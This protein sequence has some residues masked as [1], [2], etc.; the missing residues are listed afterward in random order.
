M[1]RLSISSFWRDWRAWISRMCLE[2]KVFK[3]WK[4]IKL[5]K[6]GFIQR[7]PK[8]SRTTDHSLFSEPTDFTLEIL[9]L[10]F[11]IVVAADVGVVEGVV[12]QTGQRGFMGRARC[13]GMAEITGSICSFLGRWRGLWRLESPLFSRSDW[14]PTHTSLRVG[15]HLEIK[16]NREL[17]EVLEVF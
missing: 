1:K 13:Q 14:K 16:T 8:E 7:C 4:S 5:T 6:S 15:G 17:I 9:I 3:T 11:W 2:A 12:I 10:K